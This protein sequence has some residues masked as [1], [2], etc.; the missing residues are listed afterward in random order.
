MAHGF[1]QTGRVWGSMDANLAADHRLVLVDLPGHAGSSE[2]AVGL[3]DGA[4]L[5]GEP[6]DGPPTSGTR[7]VPDSASTWPCAAR[8]WSTTWC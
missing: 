4:A 8:T 1:T 6:V 5:L 2:V 3:D 7:W